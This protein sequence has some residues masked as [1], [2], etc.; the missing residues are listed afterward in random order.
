MDGKLSDEISDA[1]FEAK[2][3]ANWRDPLYRDGEVKTQ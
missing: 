3:P 2:T 1:Y